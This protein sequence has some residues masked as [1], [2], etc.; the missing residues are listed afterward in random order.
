VE[1][2]CGGLQLVC[3]RRNFLIKAGKR[4]GFGPSGLPRPPQAIVGPWGASEVLLGQGTTWG[5]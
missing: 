2:R 4:G 1:G 5:G 3:E